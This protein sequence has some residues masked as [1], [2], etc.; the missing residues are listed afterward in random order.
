MYNAVLCQERNWFWFWT[1]LGLPNLARQTSWPCINNAR[2]NVTFRIQQKLRQT[3]VNC[4]IKSGNDQQLLTW[5]FLLINPFVHLIRPCAI[6]LHSQSRH[7]WTCHGQPT[8]SSVT[9]MWCND[10]D[11]YFLRHTSY[12]TPE[13]TKHLSIENNGSIISNNA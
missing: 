6:Y 13:M 10:I 2:L 7:I 8:V 1:M 5:I 4:C 11:W 9:D 12:K 3:G